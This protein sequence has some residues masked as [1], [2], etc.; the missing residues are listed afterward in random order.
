MSPTAPEWITSFLRSVDA[1]QHETAFGV[2]ADDAVLHFG[3]T[4]VQGLP[5]IKKFMADLG[6]P[7]EVE[8]RIRQAWQVDGD[9][10]VRGVAGVP[11]GGRLDDAD[12]LAFVQIFSVGPDGRV[13]R[14]RVVFGP[15]A[16]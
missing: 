15:P 10:I 9:H 14:Q 16:A 7:R 13:T 6:T 12:G 2:F 1:G 4:T 11:A 8:H 5:A 3:S